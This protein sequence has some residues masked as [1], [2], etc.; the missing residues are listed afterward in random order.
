MMD[1]ENIFDNLKSAKETKAQYLASPYTVPADYFEELPLIIIKKL[2]PQI[3]KNE[4]QQIAPS[5][6]NISKLPPFTVPEHYF[7]GI[8]ATGLPYPLKKK[9]AIALSIWKKMMAAAIFAAT[10]LSGGAYLQYKRAENE[11][12]TAL[13][14]L[15]D[16]IQA[17]PKELLNR[18]L[19]SQDRDLEENNAAGVIIANKTIDINQFFKNIPSQELKQFLDETAPENEDD[20]TLN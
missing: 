5:L 14:K 1:D 11:K 4:L 16:N 15:D 17:L 9:P 7:E 20:F 6:Q 12:Q 3:I 13:N 2:Q 19:N 10:I 18:F 8:T